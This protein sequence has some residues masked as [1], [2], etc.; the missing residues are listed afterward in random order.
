MNL[1]EPTKMQ[2]K[3]TKITNP[4][5]CPVCFNDDVASL[6]KLNPCGHFICLDCKEL[7]T[8]KTNKCKNI[9]FR[10]DELDEK[11]FRCSFIM[12]P[13]CRT[14]EEPTEKYKRRISLMLTKTYPKNAMHQELLNWFKLRTPLQVANPTIKN[15]LAKCQTVGCTRKI[16]TRERCRIHPE[17]PC[18]STCSSYFW[19]GCR[20]CQPYNQRRF[21][22]HRHDLHLPLIQET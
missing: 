13:L 1:P 17:V 19:R 20:Q 18:C 8:Q 2:E 6:R 22:P 7:I 21:L 14:F 3:N 5:P 11:G 12:C 9:R 15:P 10:F 4:E 16:R